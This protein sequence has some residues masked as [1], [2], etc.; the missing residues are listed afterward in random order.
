MLEKH[1]TKGIDA[2]NKG[3]DYLTF[4]KDRELVVTQFS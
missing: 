1:L 2:V 4:F 3:P